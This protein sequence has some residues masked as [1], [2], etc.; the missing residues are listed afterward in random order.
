MA[1]LALTKIEQ[2]MAEGGTAIGQNFD[3][4]KGAVDAGRST[5][6]VAVTL[7]AG[8]TAQNVAPTVRR[9]GTTVFM[10]GAIAKIPTSKD[11]LVMTIPAGFRPSYE[12][13]PSLNYEANPV[14]GCIL[15]FGLDGSVKVEMS[16]MTNAVWLTG[17]CWPTNDDFP[18]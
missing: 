13:H 7:A 12:L 1:E 3:A 2:G 8:V 9:V 6:K 5:E 18:S 16:S 4:V 11:A 17:M 10:D 15:V 14:T